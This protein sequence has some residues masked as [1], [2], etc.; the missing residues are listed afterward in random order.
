MRRTGGGEGRERTGKMSRENGRGKETG[1]PA[2][3]S[4]R[5]EHNSDINTDTKKIAKSKPLVKVYTAMSEFLE[6]ENVSRPA[7]CQQSTR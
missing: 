1:R 4:H 7:N 2:Y 5:V 6:K 3:D